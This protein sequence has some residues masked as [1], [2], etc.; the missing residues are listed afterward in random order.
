M[1]LEGWD[2]R[3]FTREFER[4][5]LNARKRAGRKIGRKSIQEAKKGLGRV[6]AR[7]KK[8]MAAKVRRNGTLVHIDSGPDARVREYGSDIQAKPGKAIRINLD[9]DYRDLDGNFVAQVKGR[10]FL[11]E[12][13][14]ADAKPIAI[15]A[16]SVRR[17]PTD[18]GKRL[19]TIVEKNFDQ[20]VDQIEKELTGA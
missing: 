13:E 18:Q 19:S 9:K 12:G 6:S 7:R 10:M 3:K 15:I 4:E 1:A 17:R 14:G 20:Y 11:F 16:R 8:S 5:E 2:A